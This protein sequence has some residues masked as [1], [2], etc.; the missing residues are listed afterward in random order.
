M[1]YQQMLLYDTHVVKYGKIERDLKP[2]RSI[3]SSQVKLYFVMQYGHGFGIHPH[4]KKWFEQMLHV[5]RLLVSFKIE[6]SF[7]RVIIDDPI[8]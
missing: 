1:E 2:L 4:L 8:C 5:C 6:R 7:L 3:L